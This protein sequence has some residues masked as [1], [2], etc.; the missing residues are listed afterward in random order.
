MTNKEAVQIFFS[1]LWTEPDRARAVCREDVTW[2]TTRSM[3]IPGNEGTIHHVG[4][5]AVKNVADSGKD[6]DTGY[7]PETM[8]YPNQ[9][10]LDAEDDHV[11]YQ[12]TMQCKTKARRAY[13]NDYL[14]LV[15]LKEGKLW[16]LQEYWDSKQ[17]AE[18]LFG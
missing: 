10:F 11:I 16:R 8:S 18:L 14:F 2:I 17:A 7:I 12:F 13:I 15:K 9:L 6:L 4:W 3:P 5:E 1:T